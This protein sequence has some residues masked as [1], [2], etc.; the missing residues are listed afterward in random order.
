MTEFYHGISTENGLFSDVLSKMMSEATDPLTASPSASTANVAAANAV[1]AV[2]PPPSGTEPAETKSSSTEGPDSPGHST[3]SSPI[4]MMM[5]ASPYHKGHAAN[6]EEEDDDSSSTLLPRYHIR[7]TGQVTKSGDSVIYHIKVRKLVGGMEDSRVIQREYDDFEFLNHVLTS[8]Y[9]VT[10]VIV[11]PLPP[12]PALDASAAEARARRQLGQATKT[13]RSDDFEAECRAL[14]KYLVDLLAHPLF[15]TSQTV[16]DF[17]DKESPPARGK[18]PGKGLF[19]SMRESLDA[20]RGSSAIDPDEFFQKEREWAAEYGSQLRDVCDRFQSML[21]SQL[22]L[23]NQISHLATALNA[24]V[25][26]GEGSNGV[27]N[28]L[29]KKFSGCL[30]EERRSAERAVISQ[31]KTMGG[32]LGL[33]SGYLEAEN[34]MLVRRQCLIVERV[35]AISAFNKAKPAKREAAQLI[36]EARERD[37]TAV[38]KSANGEIRRFHQRRL[39]ETKEALLSYTEA[40]IRN[41][42]LSVDEMRQCVAKIRDFPLPQ[43]S[44]DFLDGDE[45]DR[46]YN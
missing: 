23:A 29:N 35:N 25:G 33:W 6:P 41:A 32:Y 5:P 37:L 16:A 40:Q 26:G 28:K 2:A 18:I 43:R 9:D 44:S 36:M 3:T 20:R 11:P 7:F 38:T 21:N 22:R 1:G 46:K 14:D 17:L 30:E 15:G 19:S 39:R 31:D 4:P 10:G 42:Q 34:A 24:S 45:D 12:R 27:Y 8:S 13:V